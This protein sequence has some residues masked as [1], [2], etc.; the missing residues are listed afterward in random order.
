MSLILPALKI[1]HDPTLATIFMPH[2]IH[3]IHAEDSLHALGRPAFVLAEKSIRIGWTFCDGFK[4]VRK[5]LRFPHRDYL[6]A[7]RD[8]P[9]ALEYMNDIYNFADMLGYTRALISRGENELKV[10]A[11]DPEGNPTS[12]TEEIKVGYM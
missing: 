7:T 8:L 11:L 10:K 9:S 2:Q 1:D 3:W 12:L 6:F 4:N 5:R